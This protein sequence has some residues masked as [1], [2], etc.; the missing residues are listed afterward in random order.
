[1]IPVRTLSGR[2]VALF[3]LGGSGR[4]TAL[5]LIAGGAE[6]LAHDDNPAS[7]AQAAAEGI[8]TGDLRAAD[9]RA[10]DAFVLSPG[11]PLTHP[12]P[13][14]SVEMARAAGV[15]VIGDV[16]LFARER[17]ACAP[18]APFVAITGTNGKSTT[19]ALIAHCLRDAGRDTQLGGNIGVAVLTLDPPAPGRFYVVECSSYQI[20]LAPTLG[21]SVGILL[22]LTP[23]HLDRHGTMENYAAIKE[24]LVARSRT[25]VVG[26]DDPFCRAIADRLEAAGRTVLRIS[27]E[28][29]EGPGVF[30]DAGTVVRRDAG[31]TETRF[32]LEG[33]GSLRG[34][35]NGQNACAAVAALT[36]VGLSDTEIAGALK[37]F[38]GLAH[39]MEEVGRQG[40][41]LFVNDSK[42]TNA[43]A[44]APA[45]AAFERIRWIAGG[46]PKAGGIAAL[47][48]FFPRIAK[49]YLI[50]EAAPQ[51]A[52]TLGERIP[53]EISGTLD[54]AIENAARDAG[55]SG[56]A[57]VVLLSPACAS[58]DQF[59]NFEVRG[60]AFRESV[61]R[62]AG[63]EPISRG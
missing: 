25:A 22:N 21:P 7:L 19:T 46:L 54:V 62:L 16:E 56:E 43:E 52:A 30:F 63:I 51:F 33:I 26:M 44:A 41:V 35:H 42:A 32:S 48:P 59:R 28:P 53:Y 50:G 38:P 10:F 17:A 45:L 34:R 58:F 29:L 12:R 18:D 40:R 57:E 24:R 39:R 14:W 60:D 4:A 1:M 13:H 6:V 20:D 37:R 61:G 11:V 8:P 2:R 47:E 31:G 3:G 15:P 55:E 9:W 36:A 23:D 5:A 27:Q 49:A